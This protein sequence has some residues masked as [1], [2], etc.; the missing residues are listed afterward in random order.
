[1]KRKQYDTY[2]SAGFDAGAGGSGQGYWK[3]GPTVDPEELFRKI[4]G[5]FSSSPFGDFQGVFNQPQEV[6]I[7]YFLFLFFCLF[8]FSR[9]APTAHGA[10][11]PRPGVQSELWPSA[12]ATAHGNARSLTH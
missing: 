1:M 7:S 6:S 2:G 5:E 10:S 8:A 4:F 12:Y 11:L 3:G 9:A